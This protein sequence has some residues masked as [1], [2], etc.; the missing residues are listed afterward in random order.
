MNPVL[1]E[2]LRRAPSISSGCGSRLGFWLSWLLAGLGNALVASEPAPRTEGATDTNRLGQVRHLN[3]LGMPFAAVTDCAVYFCRWETRV[4]DYAAFIDSTQREWVK[5][6]FA[7][8]Q[9]HP[10]VNVN[11]EDATAFCAWLTTR[12]RSAGQIT[13]RQRYRLPTDQEW[14]QAAGMAATPGGTPENRWKSSL[15]WPWGATW[16]PPALSGNYA[17]SLKTDSFIQTSPVGACATNR[18]GL[19]DLGGNVWEWCEDWYND[20]RVSRAL[21]G[22]SW[23]DAHPANLLTG[24]RF[25]GTMNLTGEDIGFRLVF[26]PG[27]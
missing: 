6:D 16:P 4:Q 10:A 5:P 23:S 14:S 2:R 26:D 17:P 20:A 15:V 21:R 3:S 13:G 7:Q 19:C 22:G 24:Y 27:P 25:Q 11:W 12:E 1:I 9:D 8:A 18:F